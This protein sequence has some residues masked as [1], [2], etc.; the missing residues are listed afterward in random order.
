MITSIYIGVHVLSIIIVAK[1]CTS[2]MS[3]G[4]VKLPDVHEERA[5]EN[6]VTHR[7]PDRVDGIAWP[8]FTYLQ[9]ETL[10]FSV[11]KLRVAF[12]ATD[13]GW[14]NT[15]HCWICLRVSNRSDDDIVHTDIRLET[16]HH[17]LSQYD[18]DEFRP[19]TL[20]LLKKGSVISIVAVSAP[21]GGYSCRICSAAISAWYDIERLNMAIL[22]AQL[23]RLPTREVYDIFKYTPEELVDRPSSRI[24][25]MLQE[26]AG[27]DT[28]PPEYTMRNNP[29]I[30]G[31]LSFLFG[32]C[33]A[34][35]FSIIV[36]FAL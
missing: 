16:L 17:T 13:L 15:G 9:T 28:T 2:V 20:S 32:K 27:V 22:R 33:D 1:S 26:L 4:I 25:D 3:E 36:K 10:Q 29:D 21:W 8:A 5:V 18:H 12:V 19:E 31:V 23:N 6:S 30:C 35:L 24:W 34:L 7:S 14:G 11:K